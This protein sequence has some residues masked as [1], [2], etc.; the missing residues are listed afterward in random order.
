MFCPKYGTE[1]PE[2]ASYCL[3]CGFEMLAET[4]PWPLSVKIEATSTVTVPLSTA[5]SPDLIVRPVVRDPEGGEE[6][7]VDW[8]KSLPPGASLRYSG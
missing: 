5:R 8:L 3:R 6:D 4:E 2:N 1:T 7:L